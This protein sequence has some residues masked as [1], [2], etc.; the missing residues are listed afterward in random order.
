M[1]KGKLFFGMI[2]CISY[3]LCE[4]MLIDE[5]SL[6]D[7]LVSFRQNVVWIISKSSIILLDDL[8]LK[9]VHFFWIDEYLCVASLLLSHLFHLINELAD[10]LSWGQVCHPKLVIGKYTKLYN[11][12]F[13]SEICEI[14]QVIFSLHILIYNPDNGKA[15]FLFHK[16]CV[17]LTMHFPNFCNVDLLID[18]NLRCIF[19]T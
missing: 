8:C 10:F 14:L 5:L 7:L 6:L 17:I 11:I 16:I 13:K 4:L 3:I 1:S 12:L 18:F 19:C 9:K 15:F 2:E